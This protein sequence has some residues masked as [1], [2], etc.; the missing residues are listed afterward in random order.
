MNVINCYGE[1]RNTRKE[2]VEGKWERLMKEMEGIRARQEFCVLLGDLNKLVGIGE[3]GVPGN[4]PEI[5]LGGRL[6]RD[7][8]ATGNWVLINGLGQD[9]VHGGPFTRKD[10]AT[11]IESCLDLF[12]VSRELR[13]F[14]KTLEIDSDQKMAVGRATRHGSSYQLVNSDHYTCILTLTDLPRVREKKIQKEVI[15]NLAKEGGWSLYKKLTEEFSETIKEIFNNKDI[16]IEMK[17]KK[18][19]TLHEKI[20]FKAFGKVRIT[21][22]KAY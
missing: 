13:P 15:W 22:K 14:V 5:S 12:V 7:L 18:F 19:E 10:P 9:I 2:E 21:Q 1:Q 20:K 3:W 8:L 16:N 4:K 6:L 17:M 11:G